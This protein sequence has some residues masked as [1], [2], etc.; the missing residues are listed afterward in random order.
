MMQ[1]YYMLQGG[2]LTVNYAYRQGDVLCYPDLVKVSVAMDTG[3]VCAFEATG[4]ISSHHERQ[5]P[6]PAISAE[7]AME[8]IS[9]ELSIES[10][11]LVLIPSSG[12]EE[13][14]CWEFLCSGYGEHKALVYVNAL[15]ARQEK[16][17]LLLEDENGSLTI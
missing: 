6:K 10:R 2:I 11:Q 1:T 13:L 14:L 9:D 4:Y 3:A 12:G 16:I 17:L 8:Q 5:L 7:E 15:S